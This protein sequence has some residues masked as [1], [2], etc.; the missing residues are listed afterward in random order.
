MNPPDQMQRDLISSEETLGEN[1]LVEAAAGTGKTTQ[2]IARMIALLHHGRCSIETMTAITFTRKAAAELQSKFYAELEKQ[3]GFREAFEQR[4]RCFVGTIHSFC[5]RL[6]RERPI[7]ACVDLNFVELEEEEDLQLRRDVWRE[8]AARLHTEDAPMLGDLERCGLVTADLEAAFIEFANYPD[9][10]DWPAPN[11]AIPATRPLVS[12]L[13]AILEPTFSYEAGNDKILQR[14]RLIGRLLQVRDEESPADVGEILEFVREF[15]HPRDII[16]KQWPGG[17]TQAET[18]RAR[19]NRFASEQAAP[20]MAQWRAY[21][22]TKLLPVL[23]EARKRYDKRRA[24]LGALNFQDL[25]MSAAKLLRK[26]PEVRGYFRNRFTH[27]L[28]DEFQD[29]DPI[30]AEVMML[31]AAE[32]FGENDWRKCQPAPGSLFVVG[33]PKQSIYRFRRADLV[34]YNEVKRMIGNTISLTANFRS[35]QPVIDWVNE[36]FA[37]RFPELADDFSPA[38]INLELGEP[39]DTQ[40][41]AVL[42][43]T[44]TGEHTNQEKIAEHEADVIARYIHRAHEAEKNEWKDFLIVTRV[45]KRL[46]V[47]ARALQRLG[48]PHVVTGGTALNECSALRLAHVALAATLQPENPV[49]LLAALR[50]ELFGFSDQELFEFKQVGGQFDWR[51]NLPATV[52]AHWRETWEKFERYSDWF[53]KLPAIAALER[54]FDDVGLP[55]WT[56]LGE[57][58]DLEAGALAKTIELLRARVSTAQSPVALIEAVEDLIAQTVE[59]DAMP[60]TAPAISAVRVMNLHKVKGLEAPVVFLADP[61]GDSEHR[62]KLHIDRQTARTRGYLAICDAEGELLAHPP[63]WA[64]YEN[65]ENL[66]VEE[67]EIRLLYVAATRAGRRLIVSQRE[68][69]NEKN[70]WQSFAVRLKGAPALE[71]PGPQIAPASAEKTGL[72]MP[73]LTTLWQQARMPTHDVR[74]ARLLLPGARFAAEFPAVAAGERAMAWGAVIHCLLEQRLRAPNSDLRQLALAALD[75][76][77]LEAELSEMAMCVVEGVASSELWRRA[78]SARQFLV[79]TPFV[80]TW[81]AGEM[82]LPTLVRGV[83]DLAFLDTDGW[84]IV[85]YKTDDT[86]RRHIE[87]LAVHYAPQVQVYRR[88]WQEMLGQPVAETGLYFTYADKY[89]KC[90][91]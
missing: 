17:K 85:D 83:I 49:A 39:R 11:V 51:A 10:E 70:P 5:A 6:L 48:I 75:E 65:R 20:W 33:D 50:S 12:A 19:W 56:T 88:V 62:V 15:T 3:A 16:H 74:A 57:A 41:P 22:Y 24:E 73:D 79:E 61:N 8:F 69:G 40:M 45:K 43:L 34:T 28:V 72:E 55:A 71:D 90:D 80:V 18:E 14:H 31:L 13:R 47:Y 76:H 58:G 78:Q 30:Q 4:E 60:A 87:E 68:K 9:V 36:M 82:E 59:H 77:G 25:L 84:V 66:F 67:E 37:P 26:H 89:V 32:N 64:Q 27:L 35:T 86:S 54:I 44:I 91:G 29:T 42:R 1:L 38:Y 52:A 63:D 81:P 23:V 53:A 7:E 2:L 46:S 21:R